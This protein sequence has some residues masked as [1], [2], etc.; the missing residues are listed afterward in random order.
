MLLHEIGKV[1]SGSESSPIPFG[2]EG[3]VNGNPVKDLDSYDPYKGIGMVN[4]NGLSKQVA[5]LRDTGAKQT[6]VN[7]NIFPKLENVK[8][9]N[10]LKGFGPQFEA[11]LINVR[12][13]TPLYNV[14]V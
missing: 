4:F 2:I 11:P 6:I 10:L 13:E 5:W 9:Y 3:K 1:I 7:S 8:E 14:N 12:L